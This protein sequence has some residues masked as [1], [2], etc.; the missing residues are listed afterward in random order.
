MSNGQQ[1]QLPQQAAQ[2]R[3]QS[4]EQYA[5]LLETML[6]ASQPTAAK[7][8]NLTLERSIEKIEAVLPDTL[9]GQAP[10]FVKRAMLTFA[11]KADLHECTPMSFVMCVLEAAELG[12]CIDG[13]LGHAVAYNN[14]YKENGRDVWRKE[15]QFMPDYKA[16]IAVAKRSGQIVDCYGDVVYAT[17]TFEHSRNGG[18]SVLRHT[19]DVAQPRVKIVA[20]YA[21]IKLPHGDWRYELMNLSELDRIQSRSKAK[22]FGPWKTDTDQMRIK[23][24]IRRGLKLYCDDPGVTRILDYADREYE[25][26][27]SV[28]VK[29]V[30][31][32]ALNDV[33]PSRPA[34]QPEQVDQSEPEEPT[35]EQPIDRLVAIEDKLHAAADDNAL[36][37]LVDAYTSGPD[38]EG[39]T[40]E[41]IQHVHATAAEISQRRAAL[42]EQ[43]GPKGKGKQKNLVPT[44]DGTGQ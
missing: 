11:E 13:K 24:V 42:A 17:D 31:R 19:Y 10:R 15:A 44:Q 21:I 34:P 2:S 5:D 23:T 39:L 12:L 6:E 38:G 25:S 8:I 36:A 26:G 43:P 4:A 1:Q 32:S 20:A 9:K 27:E 40:A 16:I 14:K 28:P 37:D 7:G 3:V 22:G 35:K 33:L 18:Q 29:S 41:Q 30:S